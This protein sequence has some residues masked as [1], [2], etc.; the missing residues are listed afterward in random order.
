M[1][2][3][4]R[5]AQEARAQRCPENAWQIPQLAERAQERPQPYGSQA[6]EDV[7]LELRCGVL[8]FAPCMEIRRALNPL[9]T[10]SA[11]K[12]RCHHGG[13]DVARRQGI[14]TMN[15][16]GPART[17]RRLRAQRAPVSMEASIVTM[18]AYQF[19]ELADISQSG[20]KL[21]GSPLP[22]KGCT[23]LLRAGALEVLCRVVWVKGDQ[24]GIRFEEPV[25]PAVLRQIQLEGALPSEKIALQPI[26][27]GDRRT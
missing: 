5:P 15:A 22:P 6:S 2:E 4:A 8:V 20:A 3:T 26:D 14:V 16:L 13:P 11:I 17:F 21:R 9:A 23:G 10:Q 27:N 1:T 12:I 18:N 19:A 25:A 24:C 7:E